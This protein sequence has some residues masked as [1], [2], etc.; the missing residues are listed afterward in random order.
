M[1]HLHYRGRP[2]LNPPLATP[3]VMDVLTNHQTA[4]PQTPDL[5]DPWRALESMVIQY[6]FGPIGMTCLQCT[7]RVKLVGAKA[8]PT[9]VNFPRGWVHTV[10][11]LRFP[12]SDGIPWKEVPWKEVP[13]WSHVAPIGKV[14][15]FGAGQRRMVD[16]SAT[17]SAYVPK[18]EQT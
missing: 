18:I 8:G 7:C 16:M 1:G 4:S 11:L 2:W 15:A 10:S 12:V 17:E 13:W 3:L 14:C 5:Y 6:S 9:Q